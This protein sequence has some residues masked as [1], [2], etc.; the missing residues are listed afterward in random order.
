ML[1]KPLL[2]ET[3]SYYR[4]EAGELHANNTCHGFITKVSY[5]LHFFTSGLAMIIGSIR[6][7]YA[8]KSSALSMVQTKSVF[9]L[10]CSL[11]RLYQWFEGPSFASQAKKNRIHNT[12]K[13]IYMGL[14][15]DSYL[16][17][18]KTWLV[19]YFWMKLYVRTAGWYPYSGWGLKSKEVLSSSVI[20]SSHP[21][22]WS[23][24]GGGPHSIPTSGMSANDQGRKWNR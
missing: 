13:T 12:N 16:V 4:G 22:V 6:N 14:T 20:Q 7:G 15:R 19:T 8:R 18:N 23:S 24:H 2:K 1:E 5:T 10:S 9:K 17:R 11:G 21:G 3:K